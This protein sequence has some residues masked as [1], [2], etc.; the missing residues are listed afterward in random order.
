M[1]NTGWHMAAKSLLHVWSMPSTI[2]ALISAGMSMSCR[3]PSRLTVALCR[4]PYWEPKSESTDSSPN[5]SVSLFVSFQR[6]PLHKAPVTRPTTR[7]VATSSNAQQPF[8][9]SSRACCH[10]LYIPSSSPSPSLCPYIASRLKAR[11]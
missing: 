7:L 2:G 6:R 9:S 3:T 5:N 1:K 4:T 11:P 8:A 10:I